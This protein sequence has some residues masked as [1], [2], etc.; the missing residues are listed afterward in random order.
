MNEYSIKS[1]TDFANR[2]QDRTLG[3]HEIAVSYDVSSLFTQPRNQEHRIQL[4]RPPL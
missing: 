2:L 3:E 4:Q 1:T